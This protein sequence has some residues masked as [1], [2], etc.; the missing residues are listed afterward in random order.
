M[1][2]RADS[3]ES[4]DHRSSLSPRANG[5]EFFRSLFRCRKLFFR[6]GFPGGFRLRRGRP[7]PRFRR[8]GGAFGRVFPSGPPRRPRFPLFP[9]PLFP[10]VLLF[11]FFFAAGLLLVPAV[12]R[13]F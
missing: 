8:S 5:S 4:P 6:A 3:T 9:P 10:C 13:D 12:P 1:L 7:L 2:R 11:L